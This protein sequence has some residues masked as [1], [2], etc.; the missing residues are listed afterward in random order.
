MEI[1]RELVR[2]NII[3]EKISNRGGGVE[4][5]LGFVSEDFEG[6]KMSAYQN[7]LGGGMLGSIAN[8]STI[9]NWKSNIELVKVAKH[10]SKYLYKATNGTADEWSEGSFEEV[11]KRSLSAY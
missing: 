3:R 4:V 2:E 6:E 5:D 10:L 11:Q 1:T 8:D 9:S 7:Y